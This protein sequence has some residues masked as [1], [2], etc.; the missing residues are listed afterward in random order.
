MRRWLLKRETA[1]ASIAIWDWYLPTLS[2]LAAC[3]WPLVTALASCFWG[4]L[5]RSTRP[6]K[7]ARASIVT[8]VAQISDAFESEVYLGTWSLDILR[9]FFWAGNYLWARGTAR[10]LRPWI[11]QSRLWSRLP[12]HWWREIY[13]LVPQCHLAEGHQIQSFGTFDICWMIFHDMAL[14]I[15]SKGPYFHLELRVRLYWGHQECWWTPDAR[16]VL[17]RQGR[18]GVF[19]GEGGPLERTIL[20]LLMSIKWSEQLSCSR[21]ISWNSSRKSPS[22]FATSA[23]SSSFSIF[24]CSPWEA[25]KAGKSMKGIKSFLLGGPLIED[26]TECLGQQLPRCRSGDNGK[27]STQFYSTRTTMIDS[28]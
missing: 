14:K 3:A 13:L 25:K 6:W 20:G 8:S 5:A 27:F 28:M 18:A 22:I 24:F 2:C 16:V 10:N 12:A 23:F 11:C 15:S 1:N 7:S 21:N 4:Q 19:E 17:L 26:L 9:D